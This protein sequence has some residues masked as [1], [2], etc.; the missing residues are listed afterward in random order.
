V[1]K[2][3][4]QKYNDYI[5]PFNW[6]NHEIWKI[7]APIEYWSTN[8][9]YWQLHRSFWSSQKDIHYDIKPID[10]LKNK[11][12]HKEHNHRINNANLAFPITVV[13]W[14]NQFKILDGIHRLAK[15]YKNGI[16]LIKVKKIYLDEVNLSKPNT[17]SNFTF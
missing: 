5:L 8:V 10:I 16:G 1:T 11:I 14:R 4:Y 13:D 17:F 9:L 12:Q 3:S 15:C 6:N 7:T 2:P